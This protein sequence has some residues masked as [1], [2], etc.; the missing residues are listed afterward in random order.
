MIGTIDA[1]TD[2]PID[3]PTKATAYEAFLESSEII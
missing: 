1:T 3:D 2:E